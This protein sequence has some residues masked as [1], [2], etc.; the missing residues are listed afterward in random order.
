[1]S[2]GATSERHHN[3]TF[4]GRDQAREYPR[5]KSRKN[6]RREADTC[7]LM[8]SAFMGDLLAAAANLSIERP[9]VTRDLGRVLAGAAPWRSRGQMASLALPHAAV[10]G[11]RDENS[12]RVIP[13]QVLPETQEKRG[14]PANAS[15]THTAI[16]SV[17]GCNLRRRPMKY[18][19][20]PACFQRYST[21]FLPVARSV[22]PCET[23][24]WRDGS[25][26]GHGD[27][28]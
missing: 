7:R 8:G 19:V 22:R 4:F 16:G 6:F 9:G 18:D 21:A 15:S 12:P 23:V 13:R 1:M 10:L 20:R 17:S 28:G 24:A 11:G 25:R 14:L 3:G 26:A 2:G 27:N 5:A